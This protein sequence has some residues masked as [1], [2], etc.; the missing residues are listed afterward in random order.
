MVR[1]LLGRVVVRRSR[2][3]SRQGTSV[4]PARKMVVAWVRWSLGGE[5][6]VNICVCLDILGTFTDSSV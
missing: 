1:P 2:K 3:A 4:G 6:G 5:F